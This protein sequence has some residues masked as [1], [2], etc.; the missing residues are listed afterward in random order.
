[1]GKISRTT[2]YKYVGFHLDEKGNC[3]YHIGQKDN[4]VAGQINAIKSIA[5]MSNVGSKFLAVRLELYESC[6]IHSL[7]YG[8][9]AWHQHTK[10]EINHLE[11]VQAK[12]L[13]QLLQL[14]RSTPYL[15][16]LNELGMWRMQ[17]RIDYRRIMF[18]QNL[19]KSDDRRLCKRV[20]LDQREAEEDGT[21]YETTKE[22]LINYNIDPDEIASM[23]KSE[24][25][26]TIKGRIEEKMT[27]IISEA[28]KNM[29]KLRFTAETEFKR[30]EYVMKMDGIESLHTLKTR[31]N[32]LPVYSNYKGDIT[33]DNMCWHCKKEEDNTEH[34]IECTALGETFLTKED[35]K[36]SYN[37]ELWKVMNERTKYN[38]ENRKKEKDEERLSRRTPCYS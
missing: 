27:T 25:K 17:E 26:K 31:L 7:L 37:V 13:C 6:F 24:L 23:S 34:L 36:N 28:A 22:K 20:V 2:E 18:L 21:F 10:T 11:K 35:L 32:M 16:L 38:L 3:E 12:T 5:N 29:T 15:G 4:I 19:L 1:M 30:K 14:P 33:M 8:L 9:E